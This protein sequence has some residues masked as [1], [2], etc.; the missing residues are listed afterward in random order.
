MSELH[1]DE[2]SNTEV[3]GE[4]YTEINDSENSLQNRDWDTLSDSDGKNT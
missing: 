3:D 1:L 4:E 2:Y